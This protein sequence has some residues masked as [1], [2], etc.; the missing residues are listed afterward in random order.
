[1]YRNLWISSISILGRDIIILYCPSFDCGKD[2]PSAFTHPSRH[3]FY[4]QISCTIE[5][6]TQIGRGEDDKIV[7]YNIII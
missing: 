1:M 4:N 5:Y 6:Q 7:Y 2:V 3:E